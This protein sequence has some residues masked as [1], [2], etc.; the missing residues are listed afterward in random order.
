MIIPVGHENLR[1]RRWPWVTTAI[2]VLCSVIFL[3]AN[4]PMQQQMAQTGQLQLHILLLSA[5]Y[6]DAPMT[7]A[8]SDIVRA[9]KLEHMDFYSQMEDPERNRFI[10]AWDKQIHS[11]GFSVSD[12]NAQMNALCSQLAQAQVNSIAWNY[13]FHSVDPHARSYITATFL[14]GGWLHLIFNM[15][16]LWLAGTILEDLWGRVIY[17]V[18]YLAAGALA[19]AVHGA[20]F[21]HN[22][23]PALGASGAI[24]GLMGAFLV[25]FPTTRIRLGWV[26]WVKIIKF[27]VPA[28]VILP[29][30][31][32]MNVSSGLL[33]RLVG[34]EAGIAYWAH[35]GGFAFGALGAY[36]LR[37][38]G[39]EQSADR[40][41]E[42]RVSWTADP[43]I[44]R[45][46][47]SLAE[48][49]PA[50]AIASLRRHLQEKPDSVD[51]W[52][53]LFKAQ[54]R[55][56]D[57]EGQKETLAMLCRLR[58]TAGELEAA[59]ADYEMYQNL[60]GDKLPRGVWL[61]LCRYFEREQRWE[62]AVEEYEK[63]AH[64]FPSER[65]AASALVSAGQ[66]CVA[67][68]ASPGRAEKCFK[69]AQ[70]SPLPHSDLERAIQEGLQKCAPAPVQEVRYLR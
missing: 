20:V 60:G 68:L 53:L 2:I 10:D 48:N 64:A 65:A 44:V 7:P 66:I 11:D 59:A 23:I 15:W 47:D 69:E 17:P 56:K 27:N 33:A 31:L 41:I 70:L 57:Y 6:P 19:W 49:N 54:E 55:R 16:F 43:L 3:V 37:T 36:I 39:L 30:W 42:A 22:F 61:E 4:S 58:V 34:A 14:H 12:A 29:L 35:I 38:T 62:L 13:A 40:A 24:A 52:D 5:I 51:G 50:G 28:Y 8:A 18:F 32:L 1:G 25:R 46:T 67:H 21:P 9:Y 26:L 45:A 63:L